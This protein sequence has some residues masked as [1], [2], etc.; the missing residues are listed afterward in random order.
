MRGIA[1][2]KEARRAEPRWIRLV[3]EQI[4]HF[5]EELASGG[6]VRCSGA[7]ARRSAPTRRDAAVDSEEICIAVGDGAVR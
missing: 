1:E 7:G 3:A 4:A 2:L 5:D 6:S